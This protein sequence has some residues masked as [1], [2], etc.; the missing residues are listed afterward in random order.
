MRFWAVIRLHN[1]ALSHMWTAAGNFHA[2]F[3]TSITPEHG[4]MS[5][6]ECHLFVTAFQQKYSRMVWLPDGASERSMFSP[7]AIQVVYCPH[8][9]QQLVERPCGMTPAAKVH[10]SAATLPG[11]QRQSC[12]CRWDTGT[13]ALLMEWVQL[14]LTSMPAAEQCQPLALSLLIWAH[15]I[16][17]TLTYLLSVS[18]TM[19]CAWGCFIATCCG[20]RHI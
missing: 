19:K 2:T 18:Q 11:A 7:G 4:C 12:H 9:L 3:C 6:C 14:V 17:P 8:P 15:C 16:R 20:V 13:A 1:A 10:L 5:R